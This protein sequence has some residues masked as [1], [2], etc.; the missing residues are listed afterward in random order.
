M[1]RNNKAD[2]S[3]VIARIKEMG[4]S[5][6]AD[7]L[8]ELDESNELYEKS[9]I[10]ILDDLTSV[11]TINDINRTVERY[12]KQ[13]KLYFPQADLMDVL[14]KPE[15]HINA[16]LV[17]RLATDQYIKD[18]LNIMIMSATGCGKTFFASAF[19]NKACEDLY[20]VRYFTM[21]DLF[22]TL[23]KAEDIGRFTKVLKK[24][25]NANLIIIDD[26][27]LTSVS[28]RE[29]E[30]LYQLVNQKT[31]K[32]HPRSFIICSQLMKDE[33]YTRLSTISPSLSDAIMNRLTAKAYQFE[34]QGD[35]MREADIPEELEHQRDTKAIINH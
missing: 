5:P 12:K 30:Y 35:S 16:A 34:I 6:M 1:P 27:L 29:T 26:F 21:N 28:Q 33:M 32:G 23:R 10:E 11:Q 9:T 14:Y 18:S 24:I 22:Y 15:R 4:M 3:S 2:L 7:R 8:K 13:A 17:D 20:T 19:G 31:Y 25:G